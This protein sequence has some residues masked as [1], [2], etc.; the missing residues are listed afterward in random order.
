MEILFRSKLLFPWVIYWL[1]ERFAKP[2][3]CAALRTWSIGPLYACK[4]GPVVSFETGK[5]TFAMI[6]WS[7]LTDPM[8]RGVPLQ[9]KLRN[10]VNIW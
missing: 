2:L 10:I 9:K 8:W 6:G 4:H 3:P 1:M 7:P 5:F